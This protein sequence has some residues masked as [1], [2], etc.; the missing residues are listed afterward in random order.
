[1]YAWM[2]TNQEEGMSNYEPGNLSV[3]LLPSAKPV[4]FPSKARTQ[5]SNDKFLDWSNAEPLS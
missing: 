4:L 3:I 1:M 2:Y 5:R